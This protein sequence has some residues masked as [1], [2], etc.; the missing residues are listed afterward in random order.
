M[1]KGDIAT[2]IAL[3]PGSA[4]PSLNP[5]SVELP[6]VDVETEPLTAAEDEQPLPWGETPVEDLLAHDALVP[7]LAERD[8]TLREEVRR[9]YHAQLQPLIAQRNQ[10]MQALAS[11]AGRFIRDYERAS[12]E[13]RLDSDLLD[14]Y[15]DMAQKLSGAYW[16]VGRFDG[17]RALILEIGNTIEDDALLD[18]FRPRIDLLEA[19]GEDA[20]LFKDLLAR[21]GKKADVKTTKELEQKGYERGVADGRKAALEEMKAQSRATQGPD[22]VVKQ[23][24]NRT[25]LTPERY[26]ALS[27]DERRKLKPEE[28]DQMSREYVSRFSR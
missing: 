17:A 19:G 24:G 21:I 14:R 4:L 9:S 23:P 12:R 5:P 16:H 15:E 2:E 13:G 27:S 18:D 20:M 11:Q 7:Y 25:M 8:E 22:T 26:K 10:Q 28:I 1:A 3:A 6:E